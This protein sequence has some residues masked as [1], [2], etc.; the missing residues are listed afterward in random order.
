MV[1][2]QIFGQRVKPVDEKIQ[3]IDDRLRPTTLK[4]LRSLSGALNQMNRFIPNLAN[5]LRPYLSKKIEWKWKEEHETALQTIKKEIQN[6]TQ[7]KHFKSN[8]PVRIICDASREGLGRFCN[9][10]RKRTSHFASGFLTTFDQM[11]SINELEL[12]AVVWA[13]EIFR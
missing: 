9:R 10:R 12:L 3:T 2:I 5:L 4:E 6:I 13:I 11:Y 7:I 8:Q 1:G